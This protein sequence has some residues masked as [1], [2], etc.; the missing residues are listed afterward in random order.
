MPRCYKQHQTFAAVNKLVLLFFIGASTLLATGQVAV[1][2]YHYD[3][4]RTG[5]NS[6]ESVLIPANVAS[7]SFG[8]Q[9]IVP[10]NCLRRFGRVRHGVESAS[11]D[12]R[13]PRSCGGA[14]RPPLWTAPASGPR[15]AASPCQG[16]R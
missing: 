10:L 5:W 2:T 15:P 8:S 11:A 3:N 13:F 14:S 16:G 6:H 1:T 7:A 12:Q 9:H 4:N